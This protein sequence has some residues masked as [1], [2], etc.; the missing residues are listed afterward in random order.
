MA[1]PGPYVLV[2]APVHAQAPAPGPGLSLMTR[3]RRS[4][5]GFDAQTQTQDSDSQKSQ[6]LASRAIP[7]LSRILNGTTRPG[8]AKLAGS[9][10]SPVIFET[11]TSDQNYQIM[12][13]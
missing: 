12:L 6:D 3:I 10:L 5:P 7:I 1:W 8:W 2:R 11:A 9:I 4:D 13:G